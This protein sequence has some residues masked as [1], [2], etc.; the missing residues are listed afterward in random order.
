MQ[1]ARERVEAVMSAVMAHFSPFRQEFGQDG[2]EVT[3]GS[4][5]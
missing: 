3:A 2:P 1:M 5:G 4:A